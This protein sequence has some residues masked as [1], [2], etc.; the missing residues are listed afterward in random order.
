LIGHGF[1]NFTPQLFLDF[2]ESNGFKVINCRYWDGISITAL[3]YGP[4]GRYSS[5]SEGCIIVSAKKTRNIGKITEPIQRPFAVYTGFPQAYTF[6]SLIEA[7]KVNE[8]ADDDENEFASGGLNPV[9]DAMMRQL[10]LVCDRDDFRTINNDSNY[11]ANPYALAPVLENRL[12]GRNK[13][14]MKREAGKVEGRAVFFWLIDREIFEKHRPLFSSSKILGLLTGDPIG[15]IGLAVD[16]GET[17][18]NLTSLSSALLPYPKAP[19]V[20]FACRKAI[21]SCCLKIQSIC[22]HDRVEVIA[23]WM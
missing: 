10:R 13:D 7:A 6:H 20:I 16:L 23:C 4:F 3:P 14:L 2:Y 5:F 18:M 19:I 8:T 22:P 11:K 1:Y 15:E 12:I 21:A 9:Y 17:K